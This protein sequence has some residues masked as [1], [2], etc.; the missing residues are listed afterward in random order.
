MYIIHVYTLHMQ[1]GV[2]CC[3]CIRTIL[4]MEIHVFS[5]LACTCTHTYV[6]VTHTLDPSPFAIE[7]YFWPFPDCT[8][9]VHVTLRTLYVY[10][11]KCM[12]M[13]IPLSLTSHT[14]A[15]TDGLQPKNKWRTHAE[16]SLAHGRRKTTAPR[17]TTTTS[18]PPLMS[19]AWSRTLLPE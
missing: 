19:S 14:H 13:H 5:T 18:P 7:A 10:V 17:R 2:C 8:Y 4:Y 9:R 3:N 11:Y 16:G 15:A 1:F 12:Y 6:H